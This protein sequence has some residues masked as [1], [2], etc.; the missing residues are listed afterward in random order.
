MDSSTDG[1]KVTLKSSDGIDHVVD[2]DVAERSVLIKNLLTDL[3]LDDP[4]QAIPIPN[5]SSTF[6]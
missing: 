2:R 6:L 5:V 4:A 3:P 1:P